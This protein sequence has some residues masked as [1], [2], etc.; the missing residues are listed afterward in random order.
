MI[1][2]MA[3]LIQVA[4]VIDAAEAAMLVECGVDWLAFPLR[5]PINKEDLSE[6]RAA[7]VIAGIRSPRRGV[8]ITYD[9]DAD[10]IGA[11]CRKLD[12]FTVQLHADVPVSELRNLKQREPDLVVVKSLVVR[13]DNH[14]S[15]VAMVTE[16][17]D[18]V[19]MYVTDTFD[20]AT[21]ASGATGLVHDW[22]I[23]ADLVRRSPRPIMLAGGLTPDNVAVA[24]EQVR[25]AAVDAHTGLEDAAGRKD[26]LAVRRFVAHARRAFAQLELSITRR[27]PGF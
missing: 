26:P 19:D 5:L 16:T 7:E 25:P 15:L 20:P 6:E 23:S 14:Q 24:I 2:D 1:C 13:S 17:Y 3:G 11:F 12:V 8:L 22:R 21:G 18:W 27:I 4:G 9:V 10:K